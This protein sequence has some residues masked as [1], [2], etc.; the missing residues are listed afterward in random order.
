VTPVSSLLVAARRA[1]VLALGAL[2][3][4]GCP[5]VFEETF[6]RCTLEFELEPDAAAPGEVVDAV[7][8][9]WTSAFDTRVEIAG[10]RADVI[11]IDRTPECARCAECR[12]ES[13]CDLPGRGGCPTCDACADVCVE[14]V[15]TLTFEVPGDAPAGPTA[16]TVFND[17]GGS[18]PVP[19][20]VL[21]D[22]DTDTDDTDTDDT[23]TDL[24]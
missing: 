5:R 7:G 21:G 12:E 9:P 16:V 10:L 20:T 13:G 3:L 14:C 23:D 4:A 6:T 17:R 19:F 1:A 15:E 18:R 8:G 11:S 2:L 22:D 24:P